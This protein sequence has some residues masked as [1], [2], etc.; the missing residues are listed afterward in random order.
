MKEGKFKPWELARFTI[1]QLVCLANE[2]PPGAK[3]IGS[4]AEYKVYLEER[5]NAEKAW[6]ESP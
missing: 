4:A 6:N 3:A 1:P 5:Q 2:E